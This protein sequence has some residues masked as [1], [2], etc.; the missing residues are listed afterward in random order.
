MRNPHNMLKNSLL[1]GVAENK[2]FTNKLTEI[3]C[4]EYLPFCN[5]N[6]HYVNKRC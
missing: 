5:N 6:D 2:T 1:C 3:N 4:G